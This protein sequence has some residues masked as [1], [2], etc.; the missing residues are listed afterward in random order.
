[1]LLGFVFIF[2]VL[3]VP[4]GIVAGLARLRQLVGARPV[5]AEVAA[6]PSIATAPVKD[7]P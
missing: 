4:G 1:M 3:F 5:S 6:T 2:I 7:A